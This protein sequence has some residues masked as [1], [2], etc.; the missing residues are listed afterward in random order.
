MP[1]N[2]VLVDDV[3][4]VILAQGLAA[5]VDAAGAHF[6]L[7]RFLFIHRHQLELDFRRQEQDLHERLARAED[8][9][10]ALGG[11]LNTTNEIIGHQLV[12][13]SAGTAIGTSSAA[14]V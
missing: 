2:T 6:A 9:G 14:E 8:V 4:T 11:A 7:G 3:Q 12:R 13:N 5:G 1:S 10:V